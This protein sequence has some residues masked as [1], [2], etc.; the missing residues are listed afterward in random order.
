MALLP[1]APFSRYLKDQDDSLAADRINQMSR[2]ESLHIQNLRWIELVRKEI[3][4]HELVK[5][6][7]ATVFGM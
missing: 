2:Q 4:E 6:K 3:K 1:G 7:L 5:S